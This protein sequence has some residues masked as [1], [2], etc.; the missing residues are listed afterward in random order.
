MIL[1]ACF[2]LG[3]FALGTVIETTI[4]GSFWNLT[5]LEERGGGG[6]GR[7]LGETFKGRFSKQNR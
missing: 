4:S 7:G 5:F 1:G 2:G 3:P 6:V